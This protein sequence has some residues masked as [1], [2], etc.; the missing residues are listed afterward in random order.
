MAEK[1]PVI[2]DNRGENAVL[3]TLQRLLPNLQIVY[4]GIGVLG[5]GSSLLLSALSLNSWSSLVMLPRSQLKVRWL[6]LTETLCDS[7]LHGNTFLLVQLLQG[8]L[9]YPQLLIAHDPTHPFLQ[10][11]QRRG[12]PT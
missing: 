8:R 2:I 4:V 10:R 7:L 9:Q 5:V 3:H 1:L 6:L 12:G 11:Q